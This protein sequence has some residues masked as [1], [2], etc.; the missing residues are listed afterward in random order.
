MAI[1]NWKQH[2]LHMDYSSWTKSNDHPSDIDMFYLCKD[3]TLILGEIK[4][5]MYDREK[6]AKQKKILQRVIDNYK[7]D[8]IYFFITHDKYVENGDTYVDVPN[9]YVKEYYYK[10]KWYKPK[11]NLKVKEVLDKYMKK[12]KKMEIISDREEMIFKNE[13]N[14]KPYY[15]IGLSKKDKDGNYINGYMN[16]S[17]KK[18]IEL[19]N[20]TKIKIKKAWLDFY[21]RDVKTIPSIFISEF[22]IVSTTPKEEQRTNPFQEFG[23]SIKSDYDFGEQVEIKDVDLPF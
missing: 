23:N 17:F 1:N 3:D 6:W 11:N 8:A 20:K 16:V 19:E 4:N 12:E 9:C 10:G 22:D 14:D 5:E 13:Y 18:G 15:T 21:K 2:N 7:K